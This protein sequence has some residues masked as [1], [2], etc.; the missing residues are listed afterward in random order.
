MDD[1]G[2]NSHAPAYLPQ[3]AEIEGNLWLRGSGFIRDDQEVRRFEG[4]EDL[5]TIFLVKYRFF[6]HLDNVS[7]PQVPI[8]VMDVIKELLQK[9]ALL[10]MLRSL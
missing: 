1:L 7:W 9:F 5:R 8:L 3:Q 10:R 4:I 2:L 6:E